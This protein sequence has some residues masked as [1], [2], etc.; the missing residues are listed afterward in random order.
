VENDAQKQPDE[1]LA[2][3]VQAGSVAAFEQLV[4]RFEHQLF[5]FAARMCGNEADAMDITQETFVRAYRAI[6]KFDCQL[7]FRTWVFAIA[8]RKCIDHFRT[9]RRPLPIDFMPAESEDPWESTARA[10]DAR[11]LWETARRCLSVA[12][13]EALWLRYAEMM[14]TAQ[15]S[16]VL[17]KSKV[18]VKVLLF[19]ARQALLNQIGSRHSLGRTPRPA[20]VRSRP[21]RV[22]LESKSQS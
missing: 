12:Q 8:R 17:K 6:D 4:Y 13:F 9:N 10:D 2:R 20:L 14:D 18:H 1:S 15:I 21:A 22:A 3:E 11:S 7:S 19:R 16:S 5:A